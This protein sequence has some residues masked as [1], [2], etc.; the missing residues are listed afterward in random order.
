MTM[1]SQSMKMALI[2]GAVALI[3][4]FGIDMASSGIERVYG[5]VE[6]SVQSVDPAGYSSSASLPSEEVIGTEEAKGGE[7]PE[8]QADLSGRRTV[9]DAQHGRTEEEIRKEYE[10]KLQE[11]L[12]KRLTGLPDL[13]S[14]ATVNKVADGT[15]GMLQTM[16]AKGIR[17]VVSFFESVTD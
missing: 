2:G 15:A 1:R 8:N 4:L 11:E 10:R 14:D 12:N 6:G 13:R 3:I 17:M 7:L 9:A 5:P 16:S